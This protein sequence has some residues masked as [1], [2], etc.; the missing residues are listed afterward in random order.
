M[1]LETL[2]MDL[3]SVAR[4]VNYEYK[5]KEKEEMKK[6]LELLEFMIK[7]INKRIDKEIK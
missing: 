2:I 3:E 4:C 7:E 6:S 1:K 5:N